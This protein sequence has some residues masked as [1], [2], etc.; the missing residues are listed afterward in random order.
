MK[1]R[2]QVHD[3]II[4][5][6]AQSLHDHFEQDS[7]WQEVKD[8]ED[9]LKLCHLIEKTVLAQ[10]E[11]KHPFESIWEQEKALYLNWQDTMTN[12]S[13]QSDAEVRGTIMKGAVLS[14][15][16]NAVI[17]GG[18]QDLRQLFTRPVARWNPYTTPLKNVYLCSSSTPPGGGRREN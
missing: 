11:D 6:C 16:I 14:G 15:V 12:T 4:G 9:P 3:L 2:G 18:I 8:S 17:N 1:N 5:Q 13:M 7:D 10:M